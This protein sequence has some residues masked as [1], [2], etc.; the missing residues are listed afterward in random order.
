MRLC[1]ENVYTIALQ[2]FFSNLHDTACYFS[3]PAID[4][5]VKM[6]HLDL[7]V[8]TNFMKNRNKLVGAEQIEEAIESWNGEQVGERNWR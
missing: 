7:D 5:D 4:E 8:S 6:H 3:D 1:Y 2:K